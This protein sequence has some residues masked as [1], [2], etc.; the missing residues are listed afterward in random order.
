MKTSAN[1]SEKDIAENINT[2]S[3]TADAD[4]NQKPV[5][6]P[7]WQP[8]NVVNHQAWREINKQIES[9]KKKIR[10]G[11]LSCLHYYMTANQ[12]SVG[13]LARYTGQSSLLVRL[14]L[15][16]FIFTRLGRETLQLYSDLFRVKVEDLAQGNLKPPLYQQADPGN[17][18]GEHSV[19]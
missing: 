1:D 9:S 13:L 10:T 12:M 17:E 2:V 4:G 15:L 8:V 5:S 3:Y 16:P 19:D 7:Y 11:R 18:Q 14:H 6:R